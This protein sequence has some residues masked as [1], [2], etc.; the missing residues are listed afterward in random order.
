[1]APSPAPP[2]GTATSAA[3]TAVVPRM[4]RGGTMSAIPW[5]DAPGR[6]GT[7]LWRA[8]TREGLLTRTVVLTPVGVLACMDGLAR[9]GRLARTALLVAGVAGRAA[10]QDTVVVDSIACQGQVIGAI[11]VASRP[12]ALIANSSLG[13]VRTVLHVL[14]QSTTTRA[15]VV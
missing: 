1:P 15:D 3:P 8:S 5:S 4:H 7:S 9:M 6:S 2:L 13:A 14:F 12:P 11:E 10:A